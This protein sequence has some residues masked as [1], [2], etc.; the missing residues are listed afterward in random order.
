[1]DRSTLEPLS[2]Q[3]IKRARKGSANRIP[4]PTA[5]YGRGKEI[6]TLRLRSLPG[7][8]IPDI[9]EGDF[10]SGTLPSRSGDGRRNYASAKEFAEMSGYREF[11]VLE[12]YWGAKTLVNMLVD[13]SSSRKTARSSSDTSAFVVCESVI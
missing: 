13:G 4:E 9:S 5:E 1:M 2:S 7:R 8:Q 12:I 11:R 10:I 6:V 3:S